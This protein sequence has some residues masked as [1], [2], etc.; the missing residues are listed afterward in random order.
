MDQNI[1]K[2]LNHLI[3]KRIYLEIKVEQVK[4]KMINT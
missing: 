3:M 1:H 4:V 2:N